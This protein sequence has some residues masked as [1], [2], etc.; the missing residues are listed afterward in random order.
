MC[1]GNRLKPARAEKLI[2]IYFNSRSLAQAEK[3]RRGPGITQEA[4]ER[5]HNSA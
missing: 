5:W 1:F 4:I 2:F 3:Q